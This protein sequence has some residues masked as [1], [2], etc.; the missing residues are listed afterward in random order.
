MCC[1]VLALSAVRAVPVMWEQASRCFDHFDFSPIQTDARLLVRAMAS[2]LFASASSQ[3][4][5]LDREDQLRRWSA[6]DFGGGADRLVGGVH[7]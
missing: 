3:W 6:G 5:R 7:F 2:L 1:E 4:L